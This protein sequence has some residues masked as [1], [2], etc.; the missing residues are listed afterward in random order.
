[1][2]VPLPLTA[3]V[4]VYVLIAEFAVTFQFRT[5]VRTNGFTVFVVSPV[6]FT[7]WYP[8]VGVAVSVTDVP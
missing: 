2:I 7:K 5:I 8:V 1:M 4:I 6:Q 3:A